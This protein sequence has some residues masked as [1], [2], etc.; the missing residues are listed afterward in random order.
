MISP[1]SESTTLSARFSL[2]RTHCMLREIFTRLASGRRINSG[3]DDPAG[4]IASERLKA[5]IRSLE[6]ENSVIQRADA[7]AR[8]AEGH[9]AQLSM[10]TG[11][12][13][14]LVVSS[15]NQAGMSDAEI[16]ANQMQIDNMASSI[17]RFH[18][19]AVESLGNLR[20]PGD[21]NAE[22][23]AMYDNA[24]AAARSVQSG[25]ANDLASGN[26]ETAQT[27]LKGAIVDVA[28][29]RGEIGAYQRYDLA[30][31]L[32]SNQIAVTNLTDSRSRIVD[33]DYAVEI[34]NLGRAQVL[35]ASGINVLKIAGQQARSVLDL[36][37]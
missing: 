17:E 16:A 30:P 27:Q 9:A 34:S 3:K 10:L 20:L 36:L 29:A 32:R 6:A 28:T 22:V 11:E 12:M 15:A 7:N 5:E 18:G 25:G 31:R 1:I 23:E 13:N 35:A 14:A 21:T 8:I 2:E 37:S 19:S 33:T 26:F 24:L 4:L